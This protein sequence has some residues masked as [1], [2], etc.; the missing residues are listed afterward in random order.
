MTSASEVMQRLNDWRCQA[1]A[2]N[3]DEA[4]ALANDLGGDRSVVLVMTDHAPENPPKEGRFRWRAF[5]QQRDNWGIVNAQRL[6]SDGV[7]RC[8]IEV[9]SFSNDRDSRTLVIEFEGTN[10]FQRFP[11]TLEPKATYQAAMTFKDGTPKIRA[12]IEDDGLQTDNEI[13]LLPAQKRSIRVSLKISDPGL[14]PLFEK[15]LKATRGIK[16]TDADPDLLITDAVETPQT[17]P[18]T[19]VFR[20]LVEKVADAYPGPFI[21]DR[22]HPLT[23]GLALRGVIW[24]AGNEEQFPGFPVIMAGNIPLILDDEHAT[25]QHHI[26]LRVR[27]DLSTLT[28]SS[29]NWPILIS[30]LVRWR[31]DHL[32]GLSRVNV[33]LGEETAYNFQNVHDKA[34]LIRPNGGELSLPVQGRRVVIRSQDVG[35]HQIKSAEAD[36]SFAVNPLSPDES[37]LTKRSSGE[38]GSWLDEAGL[39]MEY[40]SI[41]W[42]LAL[43]A[44]CVL[45]IHLWLASG[46]SGA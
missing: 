30:N 33:R 8:L 6:A 3:L 38:W 43:I 25:G 34:T 39:R 45:F 46:S 4:I 9:T 35:V 42:I 14:V 20:V 18:D 19:W 32:G 2:S 44:L 29:A 36:V 13:V 40:T 16:L 23:L 7:E 10:Q 31:L 26:L 21:L 24:A 15:A 17:G 28:E 11:I 5:G 41:A 37:D 22:S 27:P 1:A 12:R